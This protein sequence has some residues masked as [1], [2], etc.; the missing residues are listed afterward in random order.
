M[1]LKT[2]AFFDNHEG[3]C[4]KSA[5]T[6]WSTHFLPN[7]R[8]LLGGAVGVVCARRLRIGVLM[9]TVLDFAW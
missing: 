5:L 2:L 4:A 8:S 1:S 6:F 9:Q 7:G 3:S